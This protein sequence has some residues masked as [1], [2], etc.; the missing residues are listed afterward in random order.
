MTA[1]ARKAGEKHIRNGQYAP[2]P[3]FPFER[4]YYTRALMRRAARR[5]DD[6]VVHHLLACSNL[7]PGFYCFISRRPS[8]GDKFY[9]ERK[10]RE[11]FTVPEVE[12]EPMIDVKPMTF[13][14]PWL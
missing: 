10:Y 8:T 1:D 14:A 3:R 6:R 5:V 11:E 12:S 9:Q 13:R 2:T 4:R 7:S